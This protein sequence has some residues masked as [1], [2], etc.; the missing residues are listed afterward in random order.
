MLCN[1]EGASLMFLNSKS[2]MHRSR[3]VLDAEFIVSFVLHEKSMLAII[4]DLSYSTSDVEQRGLKRTLVV[5]CIEQEF[6]NKSQT[7]YE[8][9]GYP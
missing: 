4:D 2:K 5:R 8:N 7:T 9:Y 3:V 6:F 1:A